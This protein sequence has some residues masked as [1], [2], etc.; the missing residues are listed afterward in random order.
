MVTRIDADRLLYVVFSF[1]GDKGRAPSLFG[2]PGMGVG[3]EIIVTVMATQTA[4]TPSL[5]AVP[6][7]KAC[8]PGM[9]RSVPPRWPPPTAVGITQTSE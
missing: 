8:H 3:R 2:L 1:R 7:S 5:S 4:F 6:P 9:Q